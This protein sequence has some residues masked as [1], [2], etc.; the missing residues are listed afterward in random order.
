MSCIGKAVMAEAIRFCLRISLW[1]RIGDG[2][3]ASYR[4]PRMEHTRLQ[5]ARQ[6]G[7]Q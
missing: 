7:V 2:R 3:T 5:P 1:A 4:A 6:Y